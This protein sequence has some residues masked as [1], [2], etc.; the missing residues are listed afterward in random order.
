MGIKLGLGYR[1]ASDLYY[2]NKVQG[3]NDLKVVK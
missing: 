3:Y 2:H 1:E